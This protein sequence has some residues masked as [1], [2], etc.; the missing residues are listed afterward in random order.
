[1][2][3]DP[4]IILH[5]DLAEVYSIDFSS[6]GSLLASAHSDGTVRICYPLIAEELWSFTTDSYPTAVRFSPN[7]LVLV[8]GSWNS[9]LQVWNVSTGQLKEIYTDGPNP[10][11]RFNPWSNLLASVDMGSCVFWDLETAQSVDSLDFSGDPVA[12]FRFASDGTL[13]AVCQGSEVRI[14]DLVRQGLLRSFRGHRAE[15]RAAVF[16]PDGR[17]VAS[18]STDGTLIL[19]DVHTMATIWTYKE[20]ESPICLVAF[21]YSGKLIAAA[22]ENQLIQTYQARTGKLEMTLSFPGDIYD[23]EFSREESCLAVAGAGSTRIW[24]E[25]SQRVETVLERFS[26]AMAEGWIKPGYST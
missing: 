1:M 25:A 12:D 8:A 13:L 14:W 15:V 2:H 24:C 7:G 4:D 11:I 17:Y 22:Y 6:E 23:M 5:R 26:G 3:A 10:R 21:D 19:W 9:N 16:S 20:L 18:A